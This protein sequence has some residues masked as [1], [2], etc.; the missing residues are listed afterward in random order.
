MCFLLSLVFLGPRFGCL[1]WWLVEPGRWD[2]AFDTVIFPILGI[3]FLPWTTLMFVAVAPFG[4]VEGW[5]WLWLGVGVFG[6]ILSLSSNYAGRRSYPG[7]P[8]TY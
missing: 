5:D 7:Y 3:V 1:L 4:N 8:V 6:D 2:R